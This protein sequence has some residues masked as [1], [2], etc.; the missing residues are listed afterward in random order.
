MI[1]ALLLTSATTWAAEALPLPAPPSMRVQPDVTVNTL[2]S[3]RPG[4]AF[5]V[6]HRIAK[7]F[8]IAEGVGAGLGVVGA[9]FLFSGSSSNGTFTAG[10]AFAISG[11]VLG[12]SAAPG[13]LFTA[14]Y[15]WAKAPKGTPATGLILGYAGLGLMA[16]FP[17]LAL[18]GDYTLGPIL[19]ATG[20]GLGCLGGPIQFGIND[21][22]GL[23]MALIPTPNGV[24]L[25]G[26]F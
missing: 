13:A 1:A 17:I 23:K 12:F 3:D 16:A 25:G 24:T 20:A 10:A 21:A 19:L 4:G 8:V 6:S 18:S 7:G 5:W 11:A 22:H 2:P 14:T 15:T 26:T 9:A